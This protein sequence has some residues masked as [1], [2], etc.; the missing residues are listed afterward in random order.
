MEIQKSTK[1]N[2]YTKNKK[3]NCTNKNIK[4]KNITL[5]TVIGIK[6]IH[7]GTI[8][9]LIKIVSKPQKLRK[10]NITTSKYKKL[11]VHCKKNADLQVNDTVSIIQLGRKISKCKS[12]AIYSLISRP[13]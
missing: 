3:N 13:S 9:V 12:Q 1:D 6:R 5:A 11:Q 7:E 2:N 10:Y 4:N 8:K